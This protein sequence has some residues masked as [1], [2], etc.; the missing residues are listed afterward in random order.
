[1]C[2]QG[3]HYGRDYFVPLK[4]RE[5]NLFRLQNLVEVVEGCFKLFDILCL[6]H[7]LKP[8]LEVTHGPDRQWCV[9]YSVT[10]LINLK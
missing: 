10:G 1:M 2:L 7:V 8:F 4:F 5:V 6:A 9:I 3:L